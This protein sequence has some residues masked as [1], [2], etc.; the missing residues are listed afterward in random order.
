MV[1]WYLPETLKTVL[2]HVEISSGGCTQKQKLNDRKA[3]TG[4]SSPTVTLQRSHHPFPCTM[5]AVVEAFY[6]NVVNK[7]GYWQTAY[8]S[9]TVK[10]RYIEAS[11]WIFC[12]RE[13]C[14]STDM[15]GFFSTRGDKGYW[16]N[17]FTSNCCY[18]YCSL[19]CCKSWTRKT[20]TQKCEEIAYM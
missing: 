20:I 9:P 12:G 14:C 16:K 10:H 18:A 3:N 5:W 17:H 15:H 7:V 13:M 8:C 2:A 1:I 11:F 6:K 19:W 4:E